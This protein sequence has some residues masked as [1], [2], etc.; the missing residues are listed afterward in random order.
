MTPQDKLA[1]SRD[2]AYKLGIQHGFSDHD[3]EDLVQD[4]FL[5]AFEYIKYYSIE[6]S[7]PEFLEMQ[8]KAVLSARADRATS[9]FVFADDSELLLNELLSPSNEK[10]DSW[11][12][13]REKV[14]QNAPERVLQY[15]SVV[16][17]VD[18]VHNSRFAPSSRNTTLIDSD[19][20]SYLADL[21]QVSRQAIEKTIKEWLELE[22]V[23]YKRGLAV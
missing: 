6:D 14:F 2:K 15:I 1:L 3:L 20:T 17:Q 16:R 22:K 7:A 8:M 13:I 23:I 9:K 19:I 12:G 5:R 18:R 21:Y 10:V 4:T 11:Y